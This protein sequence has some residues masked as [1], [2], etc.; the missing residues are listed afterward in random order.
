MDKIPRPNQEKFLEAEREFL[1]QQNGN[2]KSGDE[3][4]EE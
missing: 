2:R 3:P 4:D 1:A